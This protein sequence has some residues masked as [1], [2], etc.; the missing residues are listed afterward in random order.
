MAIATND[1]KDGLTFTGGGDGD[2]VKFT[3]LGGRYAV[4]SAATW[5]GGN[6]AFNILMPDGTTYIAFLTAFTADSI[7]VVDLPPGSYEIVITTAT[8]VQGFLV[9][10]PFRAA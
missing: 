2:T 1:F 5:G 6:V 4:G 8:S 3:L 10:I 7:A 9:R